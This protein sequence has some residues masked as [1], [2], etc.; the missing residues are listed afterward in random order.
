MITVTLTRR[1]ADRAIVAFAVEGHAR[2]AKP[3]KDIVCAGVSAVTVGTVNAIESLA[4]L[5]LPAAMRNGWLQSEIPETGDPAKDD[6][7]QLLL[8]SMVVML[9]TISQSYG[10][11]VVMREI[12]L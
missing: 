10:K 1:S 7:V 6:R 12:M 2:F 11:Y 4:G 9:G 8:E 3:G 5:E